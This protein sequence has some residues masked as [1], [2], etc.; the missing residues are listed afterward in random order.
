MDYIVLLGRLLLGGYFLYGGYNHFRNLGMLSG[1]A[2]SKGVPS[3]SA[4]VAGSGALL[5]IGG[6]SILLG[7]EVVVGVIALLI[8]LVPVSVKM[9]AYWTVADPMGRVGER[10]NFQKNIA[11]AGAVLLLLAIPRPWVLS[12]WQ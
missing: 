4:A 5:V 11:L 7:V 6:L 10:V 1:Y 12:V 9:H 2:Q 3:A 8:F